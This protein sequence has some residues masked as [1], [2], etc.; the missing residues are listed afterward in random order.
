MTLDRYSSFRTVWEVDLWM[1][2][3][4]WGVLCIEIKHSYDGF[5]QY[6]SNSFIFNFFIS[7]AVF[8]H[9]LV[10]CICFE[11]NHLP[12][13]V[14]GCWVVLEFSHSKQMQFLCTRGGLSLAEPCLLIPGEKGVDWHV[15]FILKLNISSFVTLIPHT[16]CSGNAVYTCI[17]TYRRLGN[18]H[19]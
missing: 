19:R 13:L 1:H 18:F 8:L 9:L 16:W 17:W 7:F 12:S 15:P 6:T 5:R 14:L 4:F 11:E 2:L 10:C 3:P